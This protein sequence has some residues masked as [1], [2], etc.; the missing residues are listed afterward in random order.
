MLNNNR[1]VII[2][3]Q[4]EIKGLGLI[5]TSEY[6][7]NYS[8]THA[9][10]LLNFLK[11][12]YPQ[13]SF[14]QSL[15]YNTDIYDLIYFCAKMGNIIILNTTEKVNHLHCTLIL[16]E[17]YEEKKDLITKTLLSFQNYHLIIEANPCVVDFR[18]SFTEIEGYQDEL[19]PVTFERFLSEN[20]SLKSSRLK[21]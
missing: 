19:A 6:A 8:G 4:N 20:N 18:P 7:N 3:S 21:G 11:E 16:P 15:P 10:I 5:K 17:N 9:S 12:T 1:V 2:N 14:F 13:N